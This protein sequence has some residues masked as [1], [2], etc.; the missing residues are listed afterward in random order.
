[1]PIEDSKYF[2]SLVRS[3][4]KNICPRCHNTIGFRKYGPDDYFKY[5][6][7]LCK[8]CFSYLRDS[9]RVH[10]GIY[11]DGTIDIEKN[12]NIELH[13]DDFDERGINIITDKQRFDFLMKNFK[14]YDVQ[15]FNSKSNINKLVDVIWNEYSV[16]K[17]LEL[18]FHEKSSEQSV[19]LKML[20]HNETM[21]D[22]DQLLFLNKRQITQSN[23]EHT[24][25]TT[26]KIIESNEFLKEQRAVYYGGHKVYLGGGKFIDGQEGILTLYEKDL[27]FTKDA[28]RS[29]NRWQ[30]TIPLESV[31]IEDWEIDEKIRR[32]GIVG[33][34]LGF[35]GGLFGGGVIH[36]SGRAHDI[37]I[38]YTD[39][40]GITHA[41][42]FGVPSLT[43][44]A[45]K[46]WTKLV[47]EQLV[48]IHQKQSNSSKTILDNNKHEKS[49]EILKLRLASGEITKQEFQELRE[50]L[51]D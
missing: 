41:P 12:S 40:N 10:F 42:R 29:S 28:F 4:N 44:N 32:K 39:E 7:P 46:E 31:I 34:G 17:I 21:E 18:N 51:D 33:G 13:F 16:S 35:G 47:Y 30:I 37:I 49:I 22:L 1:M 5:K 3:N 36:E 14:N 23:V 45:I 27:F 50:I 26:K 48:K 11:V 15:K 2:K 9:H 38:P 25:Q 43:G 6:K 20:N 8:K 24:T 19:K